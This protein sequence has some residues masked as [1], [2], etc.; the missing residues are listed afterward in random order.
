MYATK[1]NKLNDEWC[2][3]V[4]I[5]ARNWACDPANN[6]LGSV[7]VGVLWQAWARIVLQW[8]HCHGILLWQHD[9]VSYEN[10]DWQYLW[11]I[12]IILWNMHV[13]SNVKWMTGLHKTWFEYE[14]FRVSE[15]ISGFQE[16]NFKISDGFL[17]A[18]ERISEHV[19]HV[20]NANT[21]LTVQC[22][23]H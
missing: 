22:S 13:A 23:L 20:Y 7:A 17:I 10:L 21:I 1:W 12:R 2:E 14:D 11:K 16:H 15:W 8:F 9:R 4:H 6:I 18:R 19:L 5:W 3:Y